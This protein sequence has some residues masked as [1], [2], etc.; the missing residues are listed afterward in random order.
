MNSWTQEI[1][2]ESK[3]FDT[4]CYEPDMA[5]N[6]NIPNVTKICNHNSDMKHKFGG[7]CMWWDDMKNTHD[8]EWNSE[9]NSH[10]YPFLTRNLRTT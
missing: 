2:R 6:F 10:S 7:N 3:G 1:L 8:M 9:K 4:N 5:H